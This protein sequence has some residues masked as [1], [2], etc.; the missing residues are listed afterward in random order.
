MTDDEP[1]FR[2]QAHSRAYLARAREHLAGFDAEG[3]VASFFYAALELRLG[4]EARVSDYL[5]C[6]LK[7]L[8][9]DLKKLSD[10]TASRL[11]K[12]LAEINPDYEQPSVLRITSQQSGDTTVLRYTPVTQHLAAAHGKLGELLHYKFF[13]NNEHWL[14]KKPLGGTPHRSLADYRL[15]L[16]ETVSGLEKATAGQ[17]LGHP[18]FTAIVDELLSESDKE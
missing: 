16:A 6:A 8:N 11:L 15:F 9:K 5:H 14:L 13:L 12:R 2:Y 1:F 18:Q 17:L 7:N 3:D 10:Y 4:I